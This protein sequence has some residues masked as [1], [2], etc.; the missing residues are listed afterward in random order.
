MGQTR[1]IYSNSVLTFKDT[2]MSPAVGTSPWENIPLQTFEDPGTGF[3]VYDDFQANYTQATNGL[4]LVTKGTGGSIALNSSAPSAGGWM[5]IPTAASNNDYQILT[6]QQPIFTAQ[7][8]LDLCFEAMLQVTEANTNTS[9]W[10]VG[11]TSTKTTGFLQNSGAP[12]TSYSGVVIWK[13]TGAMAVKCQT[14]NSTTQSSSSTLAT[15]VSGTTLIVGASI[16]HNDNT[17]AIVTPYIC[18]VASNVRTLVTVG[19]T[20]NL[21]LASLSNM[22]F[23]FGV[24]TA[25]GNAETLQVD[26]V[27]ASQGRY[28]Q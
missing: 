10:F 25:S 15:A 26:Y 27:Q 17:T 13:A 2:L 5:S 11:F 14:S 6:T 16:N 23:A 4:W 20:Q 1:G 12:P 24:R 9:S 8:N 28:Y 19:A 3:T 21:T 18:T 7:S 22:Y